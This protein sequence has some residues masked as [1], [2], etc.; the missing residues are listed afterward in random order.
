[1]EAVTSI[2][3][4]QGRIEKRIQLAIPLELSK[5]QDQAAAEYTT[6]ENVCSVGNTRF[7]VEGDG[8]Q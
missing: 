8:A 4:H 1:M 3:V 5:L 2:P 7:N 6:T